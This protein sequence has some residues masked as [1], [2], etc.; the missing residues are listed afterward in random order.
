MLIFCILPPGEVYVVT[1]L[2]PCVTPPVHLCS[3]KLCPYN[4]ETMTKLCPRN[5]LCPNRVCAIVRAIV[6]PCPSC[7]QTMSPFCACPLVSLIRQQYT[8]VITGPCRQQFPDIKTAPFV[9]S[10]SPNHGFQWQ[11]TVCKS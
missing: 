6:K 8:D 10:D 1:V 5:R 3:L 2:G 7:V 4:R 11:V 9:S